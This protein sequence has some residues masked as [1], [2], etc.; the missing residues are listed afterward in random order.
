MKRIVAIALVALFLGGCGQAAMQSEFWQHDTMY[1]NN[2]HLRFSWFGHRNPTA[3]DRENTVEQDWWGIEVP[4][5]PG[6]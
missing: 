3:E 6:Q 5:V 2:D 1:R 4:Y